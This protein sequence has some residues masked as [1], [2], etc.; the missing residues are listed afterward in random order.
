MTFNGN[1]DI[2]ACNLL[3]NVKEIS[4]EFKLITIT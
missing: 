2:D 4:D 1:P 3:A